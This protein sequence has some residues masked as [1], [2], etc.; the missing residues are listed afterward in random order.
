MADL[1][2]SGLERQI[3][4]T[5]ISRASPDSADLLQARADI[6][7]HAELQALFVSHKGAQLVDH[8]TTALRK[9]WPTGVGD[10]AATAQF[11]ADEYEQI[12]PTGIHL[13]STETGRIAAVI[14]EEDIYQPD[15]VPRESGNMARPLPRIRPELEAAIVT[16]FHDKDRDK[17]IL[18]ALAKRGHQTALLREMGDPRLLV[19]TKR[20]RRH[21]VTELGKL[22]PQLLLE[23]TGG[24]AG[25][26]LRYFEFGL[27]PVETTLTHLSG[28]VSTR[29]VMGVQDPTTTNLHHNRA[30]SLRGALVQGWVR[31]MAAI[32]TRAAHGEQASTLLDMRTATTLPGDFW[33]APPDMVRPFRKLNSKVVVFPVEA[34]KPTVVDGKLGYLKV[35]PAFE[36]FNLDVFDRWEAST[37][38][39]F[40]MW[41]D[42]THLRPF[43]VDGVE[44][45]TLV[46]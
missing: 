35:P 41:V 3:E 8:L 27:P 14:R 31:E 29:S 38:L 30:A 25:A 23:T 1:A 16:W 39:D 19:A 18:E 32:I 10:P 34:S 43:L 21:I 36:A 17:A 20:G 44:V 7:S 5:V 9:I 4:P 2:P 45:Q 46:L 22:D 28:T 37:V 26:F 12:G 24:T 42:L 6:Q 13:I 33:V 11:I 15:M 40:E